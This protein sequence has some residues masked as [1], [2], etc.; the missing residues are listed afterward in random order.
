M[1]FDKMKE[2]AQKSVD[3][4]KATTDKLNQEAEDLVKEIRSL[5]D[6]VDSLKE[7]TDTQRE[8]REVKDELAALRSQRT[9]EDDERRHHL[10]M[11]K[12][13]NKLELEREMMKVKEEAD[14]RVFAVKEEYQQ[15]VEE[16]LHKQLATTQSM[17]SEVLSRLPNVTAS[18]NY[19]VGTRTE[20]SDV[21]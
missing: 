7:L 18:Y 2:E 1:F 6:E 17:Y 15:K 14:Q 9:R 5:R 11:L 8:L 19:G 12:E 21:E 13:S 20:D 16:G 4:A 10:K 3:A